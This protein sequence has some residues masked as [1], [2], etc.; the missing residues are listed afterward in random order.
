MLQ[1]MAHCARRHDARKRVYHSN[2]QATNTGESTQM[3]DEPKKEP[4]DFGTRQFS[5]EEN[6]RI[7]QISKGISIMLFINQIETQHALVSLS[8]LI[9]LAFADMART[10]KIPIEDV[11]TLFKLYMENM[12]TR[13][14][15]LI[16]NIAKPPNKPED[17]IVNMFL[18]ATPTDKS[19]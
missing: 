2:V 7:D 12:E 15:E 5:E 14:V 9:I 3:T 11:V 13:G 19:K 6:N 10:D 8:E 18:N 4:T 16:K 17:N 1:S